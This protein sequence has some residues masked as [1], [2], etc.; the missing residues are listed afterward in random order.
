MSNYE[1]ETS[2]VKTFILAEMYRNG[3]YLEQNTDK[4]IELYRKI[5]E[6]ETLKKYEDEN[7]MRAVKLLKSMNEL[8]GDY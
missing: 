6:D 2:S 5:T 8:K 7:Y 4:A 3:F 1:G